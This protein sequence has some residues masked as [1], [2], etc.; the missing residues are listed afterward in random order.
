MLLVPRME[1]IVEPKLLTEKCLVWYTLVEP[2]LSSHYLELRMK[3]IG[4][5]YFLNSTHRQ[6][7]PRLRPMQD[8]PFLGFYYGTWNSLRW[9]ADENHSEQP[10]PSWEKST[11]YLGFMLRVSQSYH[12]EKWSLSPTFYFAKT[13][14]S[15]LQVFVND[16]ETELLELV[17]CVTCELE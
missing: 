15:V 5:K 4:G 2:L 13:E 6:T 3:S 12:A 11:S 10:F 7:T 8:R 9:F 1:L 14:Y 16:I 17:T